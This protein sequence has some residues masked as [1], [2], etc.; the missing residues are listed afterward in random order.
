[1]WD[2][3]NQVQI[4]VQPPATVHTLQITDSVPEPWR[5]TGDEFHAYKP[6]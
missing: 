1:M 4:C 5:E 2:E 6:I 3:V